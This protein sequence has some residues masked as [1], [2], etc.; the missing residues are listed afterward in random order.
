MSKICKDSARDQQD[1]LDNSNN[2]KK[3]VS[4]DKG[5]EAL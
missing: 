4:L 1:V 2:P 5:E 3:Y